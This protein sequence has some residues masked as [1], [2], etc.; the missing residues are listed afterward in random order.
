ME[1]SIITNW[2]Y[3]YN[4]EGA[5]QVRANLVYTPLVS[6][7]RK[8]FCMSFNRDPSYH[9]NPD[10][11]A[12][13]TEEELNSRFEREVKFRNRASLVM[14]TLMVKDIDFDT[15]KIF[16]EWHGDDFYM[17][18]LKGGGYDAV[19]PN[20]R[21][22][23][24]EL[25]TR[26]WSV[27]LIKIS[28]H[29]NSWT[30]REGHLIPFNWF[31]SYD[32]YEEPVVIRDMLKQISLG[33]QEKMIPVLEAAGYNIDTPYPITKLQ[34]IAFNSFRSNYPSELI[35]HILLEYPWTNSYGVL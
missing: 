34:P 6:Q 7:D 16:L 26:M 22:Q 29:P 28:L 17:Q 33:R 13:W 3:Y 2:D 32:V 14:P 5:E 31:Y 35:D 19:L 4:L 23:W 15:R 1:E 27:N 12:Q 30:I 10:E 20:W 11:N 24:V 25:I 18:A 8:T 9:K 21:K